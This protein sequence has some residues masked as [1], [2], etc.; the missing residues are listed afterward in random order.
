MTPP[1]CRADLRALLALHPSNTGV[2]LA[3]WAHLREVVAYVTWLE[4]ERETCS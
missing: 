3:A 4:R 2:T 1:P